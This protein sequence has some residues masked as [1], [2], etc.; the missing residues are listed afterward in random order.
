M[1]EDDGPVDA[2]ATAVVALG[3]VEI[4]HGDVGEHV[5]AVDLAVPDLDVQ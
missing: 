4:L 2:V 5:V 1:V 3:Q